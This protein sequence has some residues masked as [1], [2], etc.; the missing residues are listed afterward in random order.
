MADIDER[1]ISK[2]T[3]SVERY[4]GSNFPEWKMHVTFIF[5]S[6]ELFGFVSKIEFHY[7][8]L[9]KERIT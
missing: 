1:L 2:D 9:L 7:L 8:A 3:V 5:Q 6:R 4:D